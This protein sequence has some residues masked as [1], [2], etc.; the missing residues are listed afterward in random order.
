MNWFSIQYPRLPNPQE[1]RPATI[2]D[3]QRWIQASQTIPFLVFG[4]VFL[5]CHSSRIGSVLFESP[6]DISWSFIGITYQCIHRLM[7]RQYTSCSSL[8]TYNGEHIS[9]AILPKQRDVQKS[10]SDNLLCITFCA[11]RADLAR[12]S[13]RWRHDGCYGDVLT[14]SALVEQLG[15]GSEKH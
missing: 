1:S 10:R 3:T 15:K 11:Q 9:Q 4:I 7:Y 12:K 14:G 13:T 6:K 2:L 8:G 5:A